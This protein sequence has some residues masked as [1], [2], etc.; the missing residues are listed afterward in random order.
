MTA[1]S[2]I[3]NE[4]T[5]I[6]KCIY[7]STN[8]LASFYDENTQDMTLIFYKPKNIATGLGDSYSYKKVSP[9]DYVWFR[10]Q[11][12]QGSILHSYI[13]KLD[14]Q[15]IN[16]GKYPIMD[17]LQERNEITKGKKDEVINNGETTEKIDE[18]EI[19]MEIIPT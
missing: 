16:N 8:V 4:E 5:K 12:S 18:D 13:K 19:N 7:D 2:K 10:N 3:Y 14:C 1:I 15:Y 17:L 11:D 9:V 6:E